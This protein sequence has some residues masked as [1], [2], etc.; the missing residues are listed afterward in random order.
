MEEKKKKVKLR[1]IIVSLAGIAFVY[2]IAIGILIYFFGM[3]NKIAQITSRVLPYPAAIVNNRNFISVN[4]LWSNLNASRFFYEHQDYSK[5]GLRV[6]FTTADGQK[7]LLVKEKNILNNLID[8]RIIEMLANKKGIVLKPDYISQVIATKIQQYD[9][10]T[11]DVNNNIQKL[12]DWNIRQFEENIVKP[13]MYRQALAEKLAKDDSYFTDDKDKARNKIEKAQKELENKIDFAEV[14][15]KY[16]DGESAKNGG[17]LEW[18]NLN[19]ALPEIAAVI[20][21]LKIGEN[22]KIIESSI[23]FHI[24]EVEEKKNEN[25]IDKFRIRQIFVKIKDFKDWLSD[26]EK[27]INIII[28]LRAFRWNKDEGVVEFTDQRMNEFEKNLEKNSAGDVSVMF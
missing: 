6:D 22:S 20:P 5:L 15:K 9:N 4:K 27:D 26:Q 3:Q 19:I 16:S 17:E 24:I 28:P 10:N 8:D 13:D 1:T 14:A 25:N 2:F 21:D 12:Y 7:R 18:L 11:N 23:G